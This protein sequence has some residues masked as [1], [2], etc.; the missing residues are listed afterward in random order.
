MNTYKKILGLDLGVSSIGWAYVWHS[1]EN[2]LLNRIVATGVRLIPLDAKSADNFSKGN[3]VTLNS[4]RRQKRSQRKGYAR[5]KLRK[6]SLKKVLEREGFQPDAKLFSLS[7]MEIWKLRAK[8]V[9][10]ALSPQEFGR[11]LY[12]LNQKRGYNSSRPSNDEESKKTEYKEGLTLRLNKLKEAKLTFGQMVFNEL[13][14]DPHYRVRSNVHY[15]EVYVE[16]FDKIWECQKLLSNFSAQLTDQLKRRIRDEIIFFQR[17]LKSSRHLVGKCELERKTIIVNGIEKQ[18][19]PNCAPLSHPFTQEIHLLQ[20]INNLTLVY[21]K[22]KRPLTLEEKRSIYLEL[23]QKEK[24]SKKDILKIHLG[25]KEDFDQYSLGKQTDINGLFGNKTLHVLKKALKDCE[26]SEKLLQFDYGIAPYSS[27]NPEDYQLKIPED[28]NWA[29]PQWSAYNLWHILYSIEDL[30]HKRTTLFQQCS[31][32]GLDSASIEKL[33]HSDFGANGF[34]RIS[35][36]AMRKLMPLLAK[37]QYYSEACKKEGY[38][39]NRIIKERDFLE[40]IKPG[41]LRQPIVEKVL[42]QMIQLVNEIIDETKSGLGKPTEIIIELARELQLSK[43][44]REK[45]TLKNYELEN[46]RKNARNRILEREEIPTNKNITKY[47]L[48]EEFNCQ[49]PYEPG[50]CIKISD[51]FS[52]KYEVDHIIPQSKLFDDSIHNKVL[53]RSEI[54]NEKGNNTGYSYMQGK[55]EK[56][57][58]QYE[59]CISKLKAEKKISAKK[60]KNLMTSNEDLITDATYNNFINRH[61]NLTQYITRTALEKLQSLNCKVTVTSGKI[62]SKLRYSWGWS[63]ILYDLAYE[64]YKI[65]DC[66]QYLELGT[67]D[68]NGTITKVIPNWNKRSDHRH[69]ALDAIVIAFTN[70]NIIKFLST[71]NGQGMDVM[72]NENEWLNDKL[73]AFKPLT[74]ISVESSLRKIIISYKY[75]KKVSVWGKQVVWENGKKKIIQNRILVPKGELHGASIYGLISIKSYNESSWQFALENWKRIKSP[76]LRLHFKTLL[77]QTEFDIEKTLKLLKDNPPLNENGELVKKVEVWSWVSAAVRKVPITKDFNMKK[78]S[79]VVD[80]EIAEI[81]KERIEKSPDPSKAFIDIENKP[82]WLNEQ[83]GIKVK[84][85]RIK[86]GDKSNL[87][88]RKNEI[89]EVIGFAEPA[90]NHHIAFYRDTKGKIQESVCT[91]YTAVLRKKYGIPVIIKNPNQLNKTEIQQ[92]V[93]SSLPETD[94]KYLFSLQQNEIVVFDH[95][96]ENIREKLEL[97]EIENLIPF[98]FRCRNLSFKDYS[99]NHIYETRSDLDF[100]KDSY[101]GNGKRFRSS[102]SLKCTKVRINRLGQIVEIGESIGFEEV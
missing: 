92:E 38:S 93:S 24:I 39:N 56:S 97:N 59:A 29:H 87:G 89:G 36:K 34:A 37:G 26:A 28:S 44:D 91:F 42:N 21:K 62:T 98:L 13:T 4:E 73:N 19:G 69:H 46:I 15:R 18:G 67:L 72:N 82:I 30:N 22:K 45:M 75:G 6:T 8:G 81:L 11:V 23:Q 16:E 96:P 14:L 65:N 50:V 61:L 70:S 71:L 49:S 68:K 54:N 60:Y 79:Q 41:S 47:I 100:P 102:A 27:S 48:Y 20:R 77:T 76:E 3:S 52:K 85:V 31:S 35:F 17:P 88:V 9:T 78:I 80:K 58:A 25:I 40:V 86:T 43:E 64:K 99:F 10:S 95:S 53:A 32:I 63:H 94:W 55:S 84:S 51:L 2:P 33:V 12:H 90:N 5:R 57:L 66:E 7:K 101:L 1:E 83:A 74:N